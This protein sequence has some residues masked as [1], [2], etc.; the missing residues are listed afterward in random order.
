MVIMITSYSYTSFLYALHITLSDPLCN[1]TLLTMAPTSR[2]SLMDP[3][4]SAVAVK[5][6]PDV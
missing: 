6:T 5:S 4:P 3:M 1:T 2:H